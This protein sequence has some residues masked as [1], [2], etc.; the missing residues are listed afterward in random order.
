MVSFPSECYL[1]DSLQ[2]FPVPGQV[3]RFFVGK[4]NSKGQAL[5]KN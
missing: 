5:D 4:K 1:S 2:I 3:L